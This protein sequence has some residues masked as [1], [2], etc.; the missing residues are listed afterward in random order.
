[1]TD[2]V[3]VTTDEHGVVEV[4]VDDGKA[5]A[6]SP[7]VVQGLHDALDRAE[8]GGR[9]VLVIG[10]PGRFSAGFDLG[11]MQEGPDEARR[12][13]GAGA[14]LAL[15]IYE[16]PMPVVMACTGHALAMGAILLLAGDLRVGT[17]G[18]F[19][20]GL[21][22][23]SI[24]MPVPIFGTE[25]ARNRLTPRH[26]TRAVNLA[27]IYSPSEAVEAGYLDEIADPDTVLDLARARARDLADRLHPVAFRD[28]RVNARRATASLV[29]ESLAAD[30]AVFEISA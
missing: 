26:F 9:A 18:D 16:F 25:L 4:Q 3:V 11:V 21:N 7:A 10:R 29:R 17:A 13:V 15:R 5:N 28:T 22:E 8:T 6:V 30:L 19:K 20:I 23:V 2:A 1:M 14:E 12:L 27:T 24:G